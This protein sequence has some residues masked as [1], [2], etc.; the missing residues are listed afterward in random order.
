[1][2]DKNFH[3]RRLIQFYTFLLP[4]S[5]GVLGI[6]A[7]FLLIVVISFRRSFKRYCSFTLSLFHTFTLS[8]HC[9]Q[10]SLIFQ[11]ILPSL[12]VIILLNFS[13]KYLYSAI[14]HLFGKF[15]KTLQKTSAFKKEMQ[16]WIFV[17]QCFV[18]F[19]WEVK[20]MIVLTLLFA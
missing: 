8:S 4:N 19:V 3:Y 12:R 5:L 6:V 11:D 14:D 18:V 10:L 9:D 16:N 13:F 2:L 17:V 7:N 1:M 15:W 20:Q